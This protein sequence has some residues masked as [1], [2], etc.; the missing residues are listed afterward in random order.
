MR[1]LLMRPSAPKKNADAPVRAYRGEL[2]KKLGHSMTNAGGGT[3][4]AAEV[5]LVQLFSGQAV[6]ACPLIAAIARGMIAVCTAKG[7][8]RILPA[9]PKPEWPVGMSGTNGNAGLLGSFTFCRR[10]CGRRT[11]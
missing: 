11:F 10:G 4:A 8:I 2:K 6:A 5:N 9:Q 7:S 3:C 1:P